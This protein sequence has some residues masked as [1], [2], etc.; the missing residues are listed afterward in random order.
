[1]AQINTYFILNYYCALVPD[2]RRPFFNIFG[3]SERKVGDTIL[4]VIPRQEK[5]RFPF[6]KLSKQTYNAVQHIGK[7]P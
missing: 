4:P 7:G 5:N 6:F 3:F 1:M 2:V